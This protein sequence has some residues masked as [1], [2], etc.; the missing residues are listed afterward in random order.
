MLLTACRAQRPAA[1][2]SDGPL[3]ADSSAGATY[4][5]VRELRA[6]PKLMLVARSGDPT[7]SAVIAIATGAG[8][9]GNAALAGLL[10]SR[11][12]GADVVSDGAAVRVDLTPPPDDWDNTMRQLVAAMATPVRPE[13]PALHEIAARVRAL[14]QRPLD[15]PALVPLSRCSA[16]PRTVAAD[17]V[18]DPG[19]LADVQRVETWRKQGLVAERS[20]IAIVGVAEVGQAATRALE[21][22]TGWPR[23][24]A[25]A[26]G[27]PNGERHAAFV[28]PELSPG[29]VTLEVALR[30]GDAVAATSIAAALTNASP[31]AA[32][33][34]TTTARWRVI[35][36]KTTALS[37][38]G[39]LSLT[40]KPNTKVA[41]TDIGDDAAGAVAI[42]RRDVALALAEAHDPFVVTREIIGAATARDT[43][44]RA[45][46]WLL[47][48]PHPADLVVSSALAVSDGDDSDPL[49]QALSSSYRQAVDKA[50]PQDPQRQIAQR[51]LTVERGQGQLWLVIANPCALSH[52]SPWDGGAT[53]L[54]AAV[55]TAANNTSEAI[56]IEPFVS[57]AGVG[58]IA[59][60]GLLSADEEASEVARRVA[61]AAGRVYASLELP[62]QAFNDAKADVLASFGGETGL[63]L[64][65]FAERAAPNR[66]SWIAPW[67]SPA[68]QAA[69]S[70]NEIVSRWR[71]L[72]RGPVR[73]AVIANVDE[74]QASTAAAEVDRWLPLTAATSQCPDA[75][76]PN[77]AQTGDH[78]FDGTDDDIAT[79]LVGARLGTGAND[80]AHGE[81]TVA[82]L[83]APDGP[84]G[85]A[86]GA[87]GWHVRLV[88]GQDAPTLAVLL[89]GG[90]VSVRRQRVSEILA[91]MTPTATEH[92][93]ASA[94][95]TRQ[96]QRRFS[97]SRERVLRL[98]SGYQDG[99]LPNHASWTTWLRQHLSQ[100]KL[101]TVSEHIKP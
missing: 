50:S 9:T 27:W 62:Q 19:Q 5:N 80:A 28:S 84:L 34:A 99:K 74:A 63:A 51:R 81:L 17:A 85:S 20:A 55:A 22:S 75:G 83:S 53:A 43:A 70:R 48:K 6:R 42:V 1:G 57:A 14:R 67:G 76:S 95:V 10:A 3:P 23:G 35:H 59:H 4:M 12:P 33:L 30:V 64:A 91:T 56:A 97:H 38:G 32:K 90:D 69:T 66:P 61:R 25:A 94:Q 40:L 73:V 31:L 37:H 11:L 13:D 44:A 68:R 21:L 71:H 24:T 58:V 79:A 18:F 49:G 92:A 47:N 26:L 60:G 45:A 93:R 77:A 87:Q 29:E 46:W 41:H 52:E 39:C 54:A 100:P 78:P 2:G 8:P 82:H 88:G 96:R 16:S 86:L 98:W 7:P 89:R 72:L 15:A 36:A 65:T 101:V